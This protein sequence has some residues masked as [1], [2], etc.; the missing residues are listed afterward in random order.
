[1]KNIGIVIV[2]VGVTILLYL[3]AS[4]NYRSAAKNYT[5]AANSYIETTN[6]YLQLNKSLRYQIKYSKEEVARVHRQNYLLRQR[7]IAAL[8]KCDKK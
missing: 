4:M 5:K 1:M 6:T 8:K 7:L 2:V 3:A